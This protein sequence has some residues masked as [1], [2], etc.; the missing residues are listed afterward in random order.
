MNYFTGRQPM[1]SKEDLKREPNKLLD[2]VR[3]DF[4]KPKPP[5]PPKHNLKMRKKS[6]HAQG[7]TGPVAFGASSPRITYE[8]DT[9]KDTL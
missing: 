8:K 9:V 1:P 2:E 5:S 7:L 6:K 3:K 4:E